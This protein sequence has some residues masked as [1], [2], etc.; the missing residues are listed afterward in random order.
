MSEWV[1]AYA[2]MFEYVYVCVCMCEC[3]NSLYPPGHKSV[4]VTQ[5]Q[6]QLDKLQDVHVRLQSL[7]PEHTRSTHAHMNTH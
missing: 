7:V 1:Y 5:H 6:A 4:L 2:C 3:E